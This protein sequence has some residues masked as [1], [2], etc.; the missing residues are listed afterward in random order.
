MSND[1][2]GDRGQATVSRTTALGPMPHAGRSAGF[3]LRDGA[4]LLALG[5]SACA[6]GPN[7]VPPPAP[8]VGGYVRGPLTSPKVTIRSGDNQYFRSGQ[9]IAA[10]WWAAFKSRGLNELVQHAVDRNPTLQAAD[11][12]IKVAHYNALAQRGLFFP[13]LTGNSNGSQQRLSNAG[14]VFDSPASVPQ[15]QY[16]LVTHQLTV[17]FT[18]DI[19]GGNLRAVQSLDAVT[20]QQQYQLEAAYLTLTSNVV[21]AAIQEASLRGQLMATRRIIVIE[22]RLLDILKRQNALGQ[23]AKADVLAQEAALAQVELLLPPL[24][25]QLAQQRD[26]LTALAGELPA[27]EVPQVFEMSQLKLPTNLPISLPGKLVDRRPDVRAAEANMHFAS[28][29]IGVAVAARL[30][31]IQISANGGS[32]AYNLAQSFTPGTNFYTIAASATAPIFDGMTLYHKQKAAEAAFEQ[33]TA[34]Y[35]STVIGAFQNVADALRALQADAKTIDAAIHAERTAKASLDIVEQQLNA[36]QVNQLAVLN[37][38]QTYLTASIIRVQSEANRLADTA[39]LFMALGGGWPAT[40]VGPIW[41]ECAG[42]DDTA[43]AAAPTGTPER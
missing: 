5:L 36:G 14:V 1:R 17:T 3:R 40:C 12:A 23:V 41:R 34:Q 35:R 16:S 9:E 15:E 25:K 6:V 22:R 39:A 24:E 32:S 33:A 4:A 20:E 38:Q 30:P 8:E 21:I 37:A 19:W 7:F 29:Q 2:K 10:N 13:Q 27:N 31:N 42:R 18:P 11:A 28:A 26:L 43:A